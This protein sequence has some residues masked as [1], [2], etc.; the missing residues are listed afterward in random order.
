MHRL[1]RKSLPSKEIKLSWLL[2]RTAKLCERMRMPIK[3]GKKRKRP[4]PVGELTSECK[5]WAKIGLK[6]YA[7]VQSIEAAG[8]KGP[9]ISDG[10]GRAG[11]SG[12]ISRWINSLVED[13][14]ERGHEMLEFDEPVP[15]TRTAYPNEK[16]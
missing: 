2:A 11:E 3:K 16:R 5:K 10:G 4:R 12:T 14:E 8:Y 1:C 6:A 7:L 9:L 13:F 15:R